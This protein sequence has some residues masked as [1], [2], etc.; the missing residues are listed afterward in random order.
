[1]GTDSTIDSE[2]F[3][4]VMGRFGPPTVRPE[5]LLGGILGAIHHN[6]A[7]AYFEPGSV[8]VLPNGDT[9]GLRGQSE[10]VYVNFVQDATPHTIDA[11]DGLIPDSATDPWVYTNDPDGGIG[12]ATG[13]PFGGFGISTITTTRYGWMWTGGVVP[14]DLI[15]GMGGNF[16]TDADVAAGDPLIMQDL[17]TSAIGLG[18]LDTAGQVS[19]GFAMAADAA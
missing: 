12:S 9:A 14:E 18:P 6:V 1:M 13:S 17:S 16:A 3:Y 2:D 19:I 5:Q 4:L 8:V 7:T 11:K 15:A 10:F